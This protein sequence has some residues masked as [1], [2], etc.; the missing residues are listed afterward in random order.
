MGGAVFLRRRFRADCR[1]AL[2]RTR[3]G[4]VQWVSQS[5]TETEGLAGRRARESTSWPGV[6]QAI[7]WGRLGKRRTIRRGHPAAG[8]DSQW[9]SASCGL[10]GVPWGGPCRAGPGAH[11]RLAGECGEQ[12]A[13]GDHLGVSRG[14]E[15]GERGWGSHSLAPSPSPALLL[16]P[17]APA[18]TSLAR[19]FPPPAGRRA[20]PILR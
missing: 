3:T 1:N 20:L 9:R 17:S 18:T 7:A 13:R 19:P 5:G 14:A 6:A 8:I 12:S 10:R 4:R 11:S 15:S 2:P 16:P